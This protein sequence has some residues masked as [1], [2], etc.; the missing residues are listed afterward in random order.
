MK[1]DESKF[2]FIALLFKH[3]Y[4]VVII[5]VFLFV[6]AFMS[7]MFS[8]GGSSSS[9][10]ISD[11]AYVSC[12]QGALN[13]ELYFGTFESK[14]VFT[15]MGLDFQAIAT[16]NSVDPVLLASIAFLET[17]H[18]TSDLVRNKNNPGGL[19]DSSR[20]EFYS[21]PTLQAGLEM[22]A[23]T[24]YRLYISQ[25]LVTISQI[26]AK[27]APIGAENDPT[28]L[29]MNWVPTVTS[30]ANDLGGLTMNCDVVNQGSGEYVRPTNG[31]IS[32]PF[33]YR[34]DPVT[35]IAGEFH[36]G[37]DFASPTGT[38]ILSAQSGKVVR[39][40]RSGWGGGY[41][42]HVVIQTPDEKYNMYAHM[43]TVSVSDG[44]QVSQGQ[45]IGAVGDTGDSTGPHLHFEVML[46]FFGERI[47]PMPFFGGSQ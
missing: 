43:S 11:D 27:Y 45:Q 5:I 10:S 41:G 4:L 39:V 21:F 26:G 18:G 22:M 38:P 8:I 1:K 20:G 19:Y 47:D 14:G 42:H 30:I 44:Q 7:A 28:N 46:T 17:T 9:N 34:V 25:G 40:V 29:N 2:E 23:S 31:S 36:K 16:S 24:L 13:E 3:P 35:G 6:L 12:T 15:G 33:G 32:S 37:I